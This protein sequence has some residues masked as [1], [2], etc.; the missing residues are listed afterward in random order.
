MVTYGRKFR[1]R[2]INLFHQARDLRKS[3][4]SYSAIE[5]TLGISKST[6]SSWFSTEEWSKQ[7]TTGLT[8]GQKEKNT[9][10]LLVMNRARSIKKLERWELYRSKARG[11]YQ[12]L[13]TDILFIT[14]IALYWGEGD[15]AE[16]GRVSVINTD[17][18]MMRIIVNF[19]RKILKTPDSKLRAGLFVYSDI[20][21]SRMLDYWSNILDIP[22]NQFIKTQLLVSR[23]KLT[24]HKT[25]FGICSVYFSN[26]EIRVKIQEWIRLLMEDMRR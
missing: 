22:T 18:A 11:E 20:D 7:I 17:P 3:G 10:R 25:Q 1:M 4:K 21:Q 26:T 8:R 14:G 23:S 16:N 9:E 12:Q 24:K 2:N 15:K 13:K 19:Y 5:K 6:L